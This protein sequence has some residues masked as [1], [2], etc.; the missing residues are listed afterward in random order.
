MK[1]QTNLRFRVLMGR[2]KADQCKDLNGFK[3]ILKFAK[4]TYNL[5][6]SLYIR[7]FVGCV[8]IIAHNG[9]NTSKTV[10]LNF[11]YDLNELELNPSS[12]LIEIW[13]LI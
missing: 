13:D 7:G 9:N 1:K 8:D 4:G 5:D 10:T 12:A 3:L 11:S 2:K 6:D